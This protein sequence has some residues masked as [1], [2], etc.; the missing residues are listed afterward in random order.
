MIGSR[1]H[2]SMMGLYAGKPTI[3]F[4]NDYRI[5]KMVEAMGLPH[6]TPADPAIA[7]WA[8][9]Q[10][11][12]SESVRAALLDLIRRKSAAYSGEAFDELRS[13]TARTYKS[14]YARWGVDLAPGILDIADKRHD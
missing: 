5:L 12:A 2:G 9:P 4:A 8:K 1:I 11:V 10:Q 13:K 6:V 14:V 7:K 3:T